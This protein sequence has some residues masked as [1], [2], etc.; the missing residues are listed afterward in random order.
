MRKPLQNCKGFFIF[1]NLIS[2]NMI[3]LKTIITNTLKNTQSLLVTNKK[4]SLF[5]KRMGPLLDH[6]KVKTM[7]IQLLDTAFRSQNNNRISV[8]SKIF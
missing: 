3:A 2:D 6:P 1:R 7:L 5:E 8:L 4:A